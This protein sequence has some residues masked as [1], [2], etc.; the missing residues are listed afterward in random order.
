M[1]YV[2]NLYFKWY[3]SLPTIRRSVGISDVYHNGIVNHIDFCG[4][5]CVVWVGYKIKSKAFSYK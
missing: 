5:C 2:E 1:D 3:Y 4:E